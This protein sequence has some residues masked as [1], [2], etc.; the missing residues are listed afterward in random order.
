MIVSLFTAITTLHADQMLW[1]VVAPVL[2]RS[3]ARLSMMSGCG[4]VF[5]HYAARLS[6]DVL[7]WECFWEASTR[8]H[9]LL[10][11]HA[12]ARCVS[13]AEIERGALPLAIFRVIGARMTL[14]ARNT[15]ND[16]HVNVSEEK[17]QTT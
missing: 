3:V 11:I 10:K 7:V 4:Y 15:H 8:A 5:L 2:L 9:S 6:H 1:H 17:A 13:V 14:R 16:T 12:S